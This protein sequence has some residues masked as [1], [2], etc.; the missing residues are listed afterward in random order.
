MSRSKHEMA[1]IIGIF[2]EKLRKS[3]QIN[4]W[5]KKTLTD[6]GHCRTAIL[7]GHLEAC[8]TCGE[9]RISYNSCRNRNCPK[10]QSLEREAWILG[11]ETDLLPVIYYHVVFTMPHEMNG[12]CLRNPA[13]MYNILFQSAWETLQKFAADE[14]HLGAKTGATMVL[15][16]WGQ[17]LSLHPHVHCIVPG[18]GLDKWGNWIKVKS[19]SDRFLFSIK[20]MSV[21]F[22]AIFLK[23]ISKSLANDELILPDPECS[24]HFFDPILLKKWWSDLYKKT[25]VVY[26]KRPFGGPKQVIEYLGRYTHKTAISNHRILDVTEKTVKFAYK[27]YKSGGEKK[28]MTLD[29]VEFLRRF[30]LHFPPKDFRRMRHFGILSNGQKA[31]SLAACRKSLQPNEAAKPKPTRQELRAVALTKLLDGRPPNWCF[32]CKTP[33]MVRVGDVPAQPRAP[34]NSLP[35][36]IKSEE[37]LA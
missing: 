23:K 25:W 22:R 9:V 14:K 8:T 12:L 18:G 17:N 29:G 10:C 35:I 2:G 32:C 31:K 7:G 4:A 20:A 26:A 13:K 24:G 36:W 27:C 11:R 30:T 3:G 16:T 37:K 21:V 34:P 1:D 6:L 15:H 33:T 5:Q 19:R 28:E